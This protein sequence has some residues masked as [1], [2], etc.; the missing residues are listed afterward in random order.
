MLFHLL[1][2]DGR[3]LGPYTAAELRRLRTAGAAAGHPRVA[4]AGDGAVVTWDEACAAPAAAAGAPAD[5]PSAAPAPAPAVR[6]AASP[7][8]TLRRLLPH[9]LL[10][11]ED[12][13]RLSERDNR[14]IA[15]AA[16]LG[17]FPLAAVGLA[18]LA[19]DLHFASVAFAFYTCALWALV[20][21]GM[22]RHAEITF[23]RSAL[24]LLGTALVSVS[25]LRWP[26][27]ALITEGW[28][29][30]Y[31]NAPGLLDRWTGNVVG[32]ALPEELCKLAMPYLLMG[33][34]LPPQTLMFYG[35]VSGLGFAMSEALAWQHGRN[36]QNAYA[37]ALDTVG[38]EAR[39][40]QDLSGFASAFGLF[41]GA[42]NFIRLTSL[43][44][45]HATWT[46]IAAYFLGLSLH[47]PQHRAVLVTVALG[48]PVLLHGTYNTLGLTAGGLTVAL[49]SVLALNLYLLKS[50]DFAQ[51][52]AAAAPARSPGS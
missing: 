45:L 39:A 4:R 15:A 36:L 8:G 32:V 14:R 44:F 30:A 16:L 31:V 34:R 35:L 20:F 5:A 37:L 18:N 33:R 50:R 51:A 22:F 1:D 46:G 21:Y 13:R 52:L 41:F 43:P 10:P 40:A 19:G 27:R 3:R 6:A 38:G 24:C 9:L 2:A 28:A 12:L 47:H 23:W 26:L 25:L 49:V 7:A 17:V 48:V 11:L 42:Q 29:Q